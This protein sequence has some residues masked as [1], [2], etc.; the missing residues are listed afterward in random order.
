MTSSLN[1]KNPTRQKGGTLDMLEVEG[2]FI[3]EE[4]S[5]HEAARLVIETSL[6][7]IVGIVFLGSFMMFIMPEI[8][9]LKNYSGASMAAAMVGI[10][11]TLYVFATRGFIP[12]AGFDKTTQQFWVCKLNSRGHARVV[13]YYSKNDVQGIFIRRPSVATKDAALCARVRGKLL[14]ITLIRGSLAD[15]EL[16]H[17]ELC[18][19][20]HHA[21]IVLPVKPVAK[22]NARTPRPLQT[23]NADAA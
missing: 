2:K 22:V 17:R 16:A 13:T 12:Q 11:M 9:L 19:T 1:S 3:M 10:A 6:C 8:T 5:N 21:N 14:P 18:N 7:V 23:A 20:L 4:R 15:I